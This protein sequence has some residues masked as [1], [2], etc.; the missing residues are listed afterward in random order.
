MKDFGDKV[1]Y[2]PGGSSGIGLA[3]ARRLAGAG[4]H[5]ILFARDEA[6]LRAACR[7]VEAARRS[8]GQRVASATLDVSRHEDVE[9]VMDEA[10]R[11]FGVPDLLVNCVGRAYPG[12]FEE[13]G[14][15]QMDE[16]LRVNF[17]GVWN[18]VHALLPHMKARGGHI[19]NV[20]SMA[21]FLGVFGYTDYAASKFA[22]V[23][24][25]EALR[26]EVQRYGI[27]VSVL[28]PPDTDTPG[29]Q[30][31][32]RTKPEETKAISA[33]AK[34]L[35]P[36]DVARALLRGIQKDRFMILANAEGRFTYLAKRL[37]PGLVDRLMDR[38]I[39]KVQG[40]GAR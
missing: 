19:V 3:T 7:E 10:V 20:S 13:I 23:G 38:E 29:F 5:V 27:R 36:D 16:T 1:A 4:A 28:C 37:F 40:G 32:N 12:H 21:G 31:E 26:S 30:V 18:T 9:R 25:S 33:S 17:H 2:V 35:Q 22:V 24:F 14:H 34:M 39:R 15:A 8:D 6:R 11:T